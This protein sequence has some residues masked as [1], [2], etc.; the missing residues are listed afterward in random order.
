MGPIETILDDKN[1]F[2]PDFAY[3]AADRAEIVKDYIY[4]APDLV[5]E[6]LYEKNA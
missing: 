4:G 5:V 2:Q 1:S 3:I 6:V